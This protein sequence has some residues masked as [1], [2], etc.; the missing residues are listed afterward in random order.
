[1][2]E[3][4]LLETGTE[5][6]LFRELFSRVNAETL[7]GARVE[8]TVEALGEKLDSVVSTLSQIGERIHRGTDWHLV[9]G[10]C[11]V[12]LSITGAC[13]LLVTKPI[14][15]RL[16]KLEQFESSAIEDAKTLARIEERSEWLR[17]AIA[18]GR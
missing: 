14:W 17:Y 8:Q 5:R 12:I 7:R 3:G 6:E 13:G 2:S 16:E 9:I 1:M 10:A 4:E 15:D 11:T 18:P